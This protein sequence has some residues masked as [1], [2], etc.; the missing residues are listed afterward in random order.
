MPYPEVVEM[1]KRLMAI[2]RLYRAAARNGFG[3]E[4][5]KLI[6]EWNRDRMSTEE[7]IERLKKLA[8]KR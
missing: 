5:R 2:Y 1:R 3:N 6:R 7:L 8:A 4:A